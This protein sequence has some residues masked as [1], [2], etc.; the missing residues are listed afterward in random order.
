[1]TI[2][3]SES[4]YLPKTNAVYLYGDSVLEF[5]KKDVDSIVGKIASQMPNV[6]Q[7]DIAAWTE[8]IEI[9]KASI[10]EDA[11][12]EDRIYFEFNIPRLGRRI[13]NVLIRNDILYVIEFKTGESE[14]SKR[15]VDQVWD[16]ALDLVNFHSTSHHASIL[17]VLIATGGARQDIKIY[18][19][20][21]G[22]AVARPV[23]GA[24]DQL[25]E[26]IAAAELHFTEARV[27]PPKNQ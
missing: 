18:G 9:L 2:D 7:D 22:D 3:A 8:Q 6:T 21:H 20:A 14:F 17:P 5:A 15:A 11:S 23:R 26:V 13:D 10:T 19:T 24:K 25:H 1:M 4:S 12:A 16:Y 27:M